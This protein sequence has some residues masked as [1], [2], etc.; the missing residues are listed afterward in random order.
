MMI[1]GERVLISE[2]LA[3]ELNRSVDAR[4]NVSVSRIV[5]PP[6]RIKEPTSGSS[7]LERSFRRREEEIAKGKGKKKLA[8]YADEVHHYTDGEEFDSEQA[9][10]ILTSDRE[11]VI[12]H[13]DEQFKKLIQDARTGSGN[14]L[15][16][17]SD[18]IKEQIA[19]LCVKINEKHR[20][21]VYICLKTLHT[22]YVTMECLQRQPSIVMLTL[23]SLMK[24][25][26]IPLNQ[27][28]R[29]NLLHLV[30][31]KAPEVHKN[32]FT[33]F[34]RSKSAE[35]SDKFGTINLKKTSMGV[36]GPKFILK[37]IISSPIS[38][39]RIAAVQKLHAIIVHKEIS[40][41]K[42]VRRWISRANA[43]R[44]ERGGSL[45]YLAFD[46]NVKEAIVVGQ[47]AGETGRE[48]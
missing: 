4:R 44:K 48:N 26:E 3:E 30:D 22:L 38:K 13:Q 11:S 17:W 33:V 43:A 15:M 14:R 12:Y 23:I 32:P 29:E 24:T 10:V 31:E 46:E 6:L 36:P 16:N 21:S 7:A 2:S 20:W 35:N 42:H 9:V 37:Q 19:D 27:I 1:D 8:E 47:E 40:Q 39:E 25:K 18:N 34:Y 41:D 5:L 45:N 28:L